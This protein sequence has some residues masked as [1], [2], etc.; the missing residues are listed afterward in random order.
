MKKTPQEKYLNLVFESAPLGIFSVD[1]DSTITSFNKEAQ[2]ITGY[3]EAEALGRRCYEV[4][5]AD[6]C[7]EDC[8]LKRSMSTGAQTTEQEVTILNSEG[9]EVPI[10]IATAALRDESGQVVG[11]VEM[12]RNISQLVELRK[13]LHD[14]Y[15]FQDII[16]KNAGMKKILERLPL[17]AQS[18]TNVLIEGASGTGKELVARALHNLSNRADGPFVA[19]NCGA[20]PD[21]LLESELFGYVKGAFTDARKDKPGRF[22]LAQGGTLLLDEIGDIS[23][24]LQVKLL[25]VIQEKEYEPLGATSPVKADVR[26]VASTNKNLSEAVNAGQFRQDLYYRLNVVAIRLPALA[27]RTDDIPL[28]LEHFVRRFNGLHGRYV[29][30]FTESARVALMRAS[31]PGNIRELENA[32]EHAFVLSEGDSLG[33]EH[34]PD[35]FLV[36]SLPGIPDSTDVDR[37]APLEQAEAAAISRA[38]QRHGGSRVRAA[39]DLGISRNTLWRKMKR[40]GLLARK[41]Q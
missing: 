29:T 22:A 2:R 11:G 38:L 39:V 12:F 25:R 1:S 14:K 31:Y 19:V 10:S 7:Q 18:P 17:I 5:R 28:L 15:V 24:A 40:L 32:V 30:G 34:L 27:Q 36:A 20:L 23:P 13:L 6:I 41:M 33:V 16:S 35:S 8:P 37:H 26:V 21:T 3:C 9:D 4:F